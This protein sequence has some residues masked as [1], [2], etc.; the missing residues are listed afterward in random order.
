M[1][2]ELSGVIEAAWEARESLTAENR[3]VCAAVEAALALLDAGTARVAQPDG[4]GGWQ[5]ALLRLQ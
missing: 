2:A 5:C 4:T 1:S 3:E